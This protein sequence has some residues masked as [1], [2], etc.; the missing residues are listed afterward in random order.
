[1]VVK[2]LKLMNFRSHEGFRVD[3]EPQTTKL[4]GRNGCGK[5]SILEALYE[6]LQGKSF[7]AVDREILRRGAEFYR[8][9]LEYEDGRKVVV[10]YD[11]GSAKKEFLVEDKKARRLPKKAKYPI[12]L[13][14]PD[15]LN[16]VGSSP[17]SRRNYFDRVFGQLSEAYVVALNRYNKA[18]RQRNEL[19]KQE[20]VDIGDLFSWDVLLTKYGAELRN[21]RAEFA[22]QMNEKLTEV[23]R[24]IAE[25][26]DEVN[27]VYVSEVESESEFLKKLESGFERDKILGHTS[28]GIHHDNY[29]FLFNQAKADGSASRGEVRSI[30]IALKFIEAEMVMK[31]LGQ[32]PVVLLD[33]VFSELDEAR[34]KCLVKNFQNN[35]III[36]S[37]N[38]N[39]DSGDAVVL[40]K[41][42]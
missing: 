15:D 34:Q 26:E 1:M 24:S 4:I 8:V 38:D 35:Q 19:L 3:F 28:F 30:V 16:L 7:R 17:T 31:K 11:G 13:F 20:M 29:E 37:C 36:T 14:D 32:V 21:M 9:E 27:L 2:R 10:V 5:T 42:G 33:D 22:E 23:Y 12:V 18:L 6:A 39:N 40:R 41:E 25:N